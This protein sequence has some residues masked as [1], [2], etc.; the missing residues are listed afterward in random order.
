MIAEGELAATDADALSVRIVSVLAAFLIVTLY[1]NEY[2]PVAE[3]V[4][5][6]TTDEVFSSQARVTP[7]GRLPETSLT[8]TFSP[9]V[10][11]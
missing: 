8:T 1:V 5:F 9:L 3:A 4:P 10:T 11:T 6:T 7:L 2:F